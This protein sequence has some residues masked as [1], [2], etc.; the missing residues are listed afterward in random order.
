MPNGRTLPVYLI[1]TEGFSGIGGRT[2]K[3]Y[4]ANLFG[5]MSLM[6]SAV[7]FNT[8]F[9]VDASTVSMLNRF[10]SHAVSVLKEL[11]LHQTVVSRRPPT[12][13]WT[14]QN[15]NQFNLA[16]SKLTVEQLH[17]MLWRA[18]TDGFNQRRPNCLALVEERR[19]AWITLLA[20][21]RPAFASGQASARGRR[22][23]RQHC[24]AR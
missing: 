23:R 13:L 6:S 8:V 3:T 17:E 16:N 20:L 18:S 24:K 4:E 5:L 22:G 21:C 10:A 12:L 7:I 19:T 2:S 14:V 9:P 11:N 15:F 1:D